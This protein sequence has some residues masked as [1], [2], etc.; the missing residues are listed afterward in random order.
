M[1]IDLIEPYY[2]TDGGRCDLRQR[3]D[4]AVRGGGVVGRG[5]AG[6]AHDSSVP[7]SARDAQ[8]HRGYVRADQRRA[9]N[10]RT[11]AP[12]RNDRGCD[13]DRRAPRSTKNSTKIRDPEM[14]QGVLVRHELVATRSNAAGLGEQAHRY[15]WIRRTASGRRSCS[16]SKSHLNKRRNFSS[17]LRRTIRTR[18]VRRSTTCL[19]T[20]ARR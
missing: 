3:V 10:E 20:V 15:I 19:R 11:A 1:L 2:P 18:L 4:M 17:T 9:G 7:A 12:L 8:A 5:G 16:P 14:R 6:R 13:D